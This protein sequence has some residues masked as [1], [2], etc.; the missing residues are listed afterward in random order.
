M[1]D[2]KYKSKKTVKLLCLLLF[3]FVLPAQSHAESSSLP[4]ALTKIKPSVVAVGTF[5]AK[6]NP[7][8]QFLGTGFAVGDGSLVVTNA[9]VVPVSLD[10]EHLEEIAVFYRQ[11][12]EDKAI[13]AKLAVLDK[14]H[15][16]AVLKLAGS[17]LPAVKL[18]NA[19]AVR[20]G[21]LYAFTGYPMGM[22]LGLYPVTHRGIISAI[23]PNAIP[24]M[25]PGKINPKVLKQM[26]NPYD[27]FQLDATAY[28][29]N[30]GSPLYEIETGD[31]VG[32]VNKVFVQES[33]ESALAKPSGISYAIPVNHIEKLLSEKG[34]K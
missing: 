22:V 8:A 31:V 11:G 28:P 13:L 24:M 14:S 32:I 4:A 7:R 9:H 16:L 26:Q 18:G 19:S 3:Y 20:E 34:L 5:M 30:S 33:K 21:Q 17:L 15:D 27:V 29:G 12:N 1:T 10:V 23:S 2:C 25:V 6:R